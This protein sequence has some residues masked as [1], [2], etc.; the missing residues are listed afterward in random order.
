MQSAYHNLPT[1]NGIM[2]GAGRT[3]AARS[4]SHK[5]DD[6]AAEFALDIGAAYPPEAG[7]ETWTRTLR[8]D[9]AKNEVVVRDAF[10]LQKAGG[11][12]DFSLMTPCAVS[13]SGGVIQLAGAVMILFDAS[14][15]HVAVEDIKTDDA[16][17]RSVWG[18]SL[19]RILLKA[20]DL[21][22]KGEFTIRIQ[23]A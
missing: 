10:V 8:L 16:R 11:T 19:R 15:L 4:V 17:L 9:R 5:S 20:K 6:S 14:K 13:V 7:I 21:P 1:V 18:E 23:Q 2:Q 12:V 22:G 3:F